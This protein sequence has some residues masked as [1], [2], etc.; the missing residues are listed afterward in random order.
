M[1]DLDEVDAAAALALLRGRVE[2]AQEAQE[3]CAELLRAQLEL[4]QEQRAPPNEP[5]PGDARARG[6]MLL[7]LD[8]ERLRDLFLQTARTPANWARLR[9]LFGAPPFHFLRPQDSNVLRA[10]GF[11]RGRKNMAY[12]EAGR[13]ASY[14]QFGA[15]QLEDDLNRKYRFHQLTDQLPG[16]DFLAAHGDKNVLLQVR[17]PRRGQRQSAAKARRVPFPRPGERLAL[18]NTQQLLRARGLKS[19]PSALVKVRRLVPRE[20]GAHT[21][22]LLVSPES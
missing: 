1:E 9:P 15:G 3:R 20:E 16:I 21:A 8:D 11:A 22:L 12:E 19:S 13:A 4:A 7:L 14:A 5:I 2:S 18:Q 17:L 10:A 6:A